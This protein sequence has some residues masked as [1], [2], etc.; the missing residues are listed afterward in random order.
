MDLLLPSKITI[1]ICVLISIYSW[2]S[3]FRS[4]TT[5][6]YSS[7]TFVCV[8]RSLVRALLETCKTPSTLTLTASPPFRVVIYR[9]FNLVGFVTRLGVLGCRSGSICS[10]GEQGMFHC[11]AL[12]GCICWYCTVV[13]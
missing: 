5:N 12:F 7:S 1:V 4:E 11:A 2:F 10:L 6:S 13:S 3:I 8:D 9:S